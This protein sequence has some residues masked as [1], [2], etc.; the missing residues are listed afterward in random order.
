MRC[1]VAIAS[2][3]FAVRPADAC[4]CHE[5]P[6]PCE[7]F[8][9]TDAVFTGKV[10]SV[11]E[12][13]DH[14][15]L[16]TFE[17]T[18]TLRGTVPK[19]VVVR[20]GGVCGAMFEAGESYFV[21]ASGSGAQLSA[22]LC[23]RTRR[24]SEATEDLDY[25]KNMSS[26]KKATIEGTVTLEKKDDP[27]PHAGVK[28]RISNGSLA[29]V[30]VVTDKDGKYRAE[31]APGTYT[32]D[33]VGGPTRVWQN[34]TLKAS[35]PNAASCWR[36]DIRTIWN[37]RIR[38]HITNH[39]GK[40]AANVNVSANATDGHQHWRLSVQTDA[41]G[42]Y[43]IP[44]VQLGKYRIAVNDTLEGGPDAT[45]PIPTTFYPGVADQA[46]AKVVEMT[47]KGLV[48]GID[49]KVPKP[50]TVFT[51]SGVVKRDGKPIVGQQVNIDVPL[52]DYGRR[53]GMPTDANGHFAFKDIAGVTVKLE[54]CRPDAGPDNYQTAC[55]FVEKKLDKDIVVDI[56]YPK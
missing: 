20:G 33:V 29:A 27:T 47:N 11:V 43:E 50:L 39:D 1:V 21:Y 17:V 35:L 38:G 16:A 5:P 9:I 10:T 8:W 23:S 18:K 13:K 25:V 44:E 24:L 30:E 36:E 2:V 41:N 4:S 26:I 55:K 22:S 14:V 28:V 53:T 42:D 32:I 48:T 46:K 7:S 54:V 19:T 51:I 31:V 52:G 15:D 6:P 12:G 56:D 49:F 37:G 45:S 40:P 3:V 34:K